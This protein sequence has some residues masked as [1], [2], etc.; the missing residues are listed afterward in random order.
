MKKYYYY[1]QNDQQY[2]DSNKIFAKY[3]KE[4]SPEWQALKKGLQEMLFEHIG[5]R[6]KNR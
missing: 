5:Y 3:E 4:N 2:N 6:A 1:L